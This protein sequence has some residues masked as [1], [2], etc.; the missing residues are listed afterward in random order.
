MFKSLLIANRGETNGAKTSV[1][2]IE[3][4]ELFTALEFGLMPRHGEPEEVLQ[5]F[6]QDHELVGLAVSRGEH[7]DRS[8]RDQYV[9][10]AFYRFHVTPHT[11][12]TPDLQVI[13][14]PA[15]NHEEDRIA[16]GSARLRTF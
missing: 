3:R 1:G 15:E 7:S 11:H 6:G 16:I 8:S 4:G 10:E 14:E 2:Q 12:L 9:L 13:F 5:P